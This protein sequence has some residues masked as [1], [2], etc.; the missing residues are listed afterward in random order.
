MGGG[1]ARILVFIP[2]ATLAM[3][4][5]TKCN[6]SLPVTSCKV[7]DF[8]ARGVSSGHVH[9]SFSSQGTTVGH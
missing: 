4:A 7:L 3:A 6:A 5:G 1:I 8:M 9:S 2:E